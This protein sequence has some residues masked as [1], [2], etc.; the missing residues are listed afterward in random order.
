LPPTH[1]WASAAWCAPGLVAHQ[2]ALQG[3]A[4]LEVPD[5]G[6]PPSD[7][8]RLTYP[9]RGDEPARPRLPDLTAPAFPA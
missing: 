1:I 9:P 4:L 6:Q 5:F 3:G 8:P 2:S 7:W